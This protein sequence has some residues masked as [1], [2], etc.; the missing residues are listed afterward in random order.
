MKNKIHHKIICSLI[1]V[2]KKEQ[3]TVMYVK[4]IFSDHSD[5]H[6]N[7]I[8]PCVDAHECTQENVITL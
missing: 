4:Y 5:A 2:I 7:I 6:E 3:I 8:M 1:H